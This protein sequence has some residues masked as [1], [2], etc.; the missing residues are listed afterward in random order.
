M[1]FI[2]ILATFAA[3]QHMLEMGNRNDEYLAAMTLTDILLKNAIKDIDEVPGLLKDMPDAL[4][5]FERLKK[6]TP[7]LNSLA[8]LKA[9]LEWIRFL[10]K[11]DTKNPVEDLFFQEEPVYYDTPDA[12]V[13]TD[14]DFIPYKEITSYEDYEVVTSVVYAQS[15]ALEEYDIVILA[16]RRIKTK[17]H[18]KICL[19]SWKELLGR[20][21]QRLSEIKKRY[22]NESIMV[23]VPFF[24]YQDDIDHTIACYKRVM[25]IIDTLFEDEIY[26]DESVTSDVPHLRIVPL[27]LDAFRGY[28]Q[29]LEENN[30]PGSHYVQEEMARRGMFSKLNMGNSNGYRIH[31]L[32]DKNASSAVE[33]ETAEKLSG[34]LINRVG[35]L[36][37]MLYGLIEDKSLLTKIAHFAL[38]DGK[39]F[40]ERPSSNT[41]Y[42]YIAHP[43]ERMFDTF[44]KKGFV[45]TKLI[46][47]GFPEDTLDTI[48]KDLRK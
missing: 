9:E 48:I 19:K 13:V 43:L 27:V 40:K 7:S 29:S 33:D 3:K 6:A 10:N 15:S 32:G 21:L 4:S 24:Y 42:T 25:L 36:Y 12:F 11:Q 18:R 1:D 22:S 8:D 37:C 2:R 17:L 20:V 41:E 26:D 46:E 35:V 23:R 5:L 30:L 47:Y 28:A 34:E 31:L 38:N 44:E 16:L 45:E 14:T 39:P